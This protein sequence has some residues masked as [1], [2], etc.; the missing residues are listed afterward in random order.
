MISPLVVDQRGEEER[1]SSCSS[2]QRATDGRKYGVISRHC[3][4]R[5]FSR[6]DVFLYLKKLECAVTEIK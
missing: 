2:Q 6:A 4:Y 1:G 5:L 3:I